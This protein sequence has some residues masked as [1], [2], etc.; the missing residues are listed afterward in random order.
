MENRQK[1]YFMSEQVKEFGLT[2]P[3]Y[4]DF[5][6]IQTDE[7]WKWLKRDRKNQ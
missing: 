7:V 2:I 5:V 3:I 6:I 4:N 1:D